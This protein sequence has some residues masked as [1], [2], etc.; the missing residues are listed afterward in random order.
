MPRRRVALCVLL[1]VL[2]A[3]AQAA[4]ATP[5]DSAEIGRSRLAA[6]DTVV[7]DLHL[8]AENTTGDEQELRRAMAPYVAA[9]RVAARARATSHAI[10]AARRRG[11]TPP[12]IGPLTVRRWLRVRVRA[13]DARVRFLGY[14]TISRPGLGVVHRPLER[15][16]VR[17]HREHGTWKL[18]WWSARWLTPAGPLGVPG[19]QARITP[20]DLR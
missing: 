14:L 15:Y 4:A 20:R 10:R 7:L 13:A 5:T 9:D 12:Q 18:V 16:R 17:L 8:G 6:L 11:W 19:D 2:S 3:A 1:A